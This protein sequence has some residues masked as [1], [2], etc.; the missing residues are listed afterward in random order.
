MRGN[1]LFIGLMQCSAFESVKIYFK[2]DKTF[3]ISL[4]IPCME[5]LLSFYQTATMVG[6]QTRI[7]RDL[8]SKPPAPSGS[9]F[10]VASKK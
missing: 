7:G 4:D 6:T 3:G 2:G 5:C 10:A 9:D 8:P 1:Y